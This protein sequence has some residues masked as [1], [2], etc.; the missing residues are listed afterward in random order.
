MLSEKTIAAVIP[1]YNEESQIGHVIETLPDF[2]DKIIVI[3]DKSSDKTIEVVE[4]LQSSNDKILLIKHDKNQGNG[5]ARIT[6]LKKCLT[7]NTDIICLLDGDGQMDIEELPNL[8]KPVLDG[9]A[10]LVKGNSF[11][12]SGRKDRE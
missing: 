4:S 2:I 5:A 12:H 7:I 10:D 11:F 1:C 9:D 8:L 6:G 3:D